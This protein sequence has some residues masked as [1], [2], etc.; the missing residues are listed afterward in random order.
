LGRFHRNLRLRARPGHVALFPEHPFQK[1]EFRPLPNGIFHPEVLDQQREILCNL[2]EGLGRFGGFHPGKTGFGIFGQIPG[3]E[4]RRK[5]RARFFPNPEELSEKF[6][7][8]SDEQSNSPQLPHVGEQMGGIE[9][10]GGG[11]HPKHLAKGIG[12][13]PE[14]HRID[15]FGDAE[16][17]V[18]TPG[19]IRNIHKRIRRVGNVERILPVNPEQ[20]RIP[21][22]VIGEIEHLLQHHPAEHDIEFLGRSS[23]ELP[24]MPAKTIHRKTVEEILPE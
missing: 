5:R 16:L 12:E 17:T 10:L 19:P 13:F 21:R 23:P 22:L 11:I 9:P 6:P 1:L 2:L 14:H 15:P 24:K 4:F 3:G 18:G 8:C 20:K 7:D